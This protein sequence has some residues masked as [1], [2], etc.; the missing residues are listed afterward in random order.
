MPA[1]LKRTSKRPWRSTPAVTARSTAA[2]SVTSARALEP[3]SSSAASRSFSS[4]MPTRCTLAPSATNSRAVA[5]PIPLSPPVISATLSSSRPIAAPTLSQ[6]RAGRGV[7]GRRHR[8]DPAAR[9]RVDVGRLV[10]AADRLVEQRPGV[11][12]AVDA[13][14]RRRALV[15]ARRQGV[16]ERAALALLAAGGVAEAALVPGEAS[17]EERRADEGLARQADD[18]EG[19]LARGAVAEVV[20]AQLGLVDARAPAAAVADGEREVLAP[21]LEVLD[22]PPGRRPVDAR[23][24]VAAALLRHA[25]QAPRG[26]GSRRAERLGVHDRVRL[27]AAA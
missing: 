1:L 18:L 22:G 20:G 5:S 19:D 9:V 26:L 7:R 23:V 24:D 17:V 2:S 3:P 8:V 4:S 14:R 27:A 13:D 15:G 21:E 6:R 11:G 10:R 16:A 12:E 25:G